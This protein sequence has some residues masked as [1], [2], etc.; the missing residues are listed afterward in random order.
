MFLNYYVSGEFLITFACDRLRQ[1][2]T[3]MKMN[4]LLGE[5][6]LVNIAGDYACT[7]G[8]HRIITALKAS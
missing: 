3:Y 1:I 8:M 7:Y 4:C 5:A 2:I 6:F